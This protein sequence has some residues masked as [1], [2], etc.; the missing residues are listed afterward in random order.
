MTLSALKQATQL[1]GYTVFDYSDFFTK[2]F[3]AGLGLYSKTKT[4]KGL[5]VKDSK[6]NIIIFI[7]DSISEEKQLFVLAHELGH[8]LLNHLDNPNSN[9]K[10]Q[11]I[12]ADRFAMAITGRTSFLENETM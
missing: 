10:Q 2:M 6:G 5:T 7:D 3:L 4:A 9:G 12:E 11:E 1:H 8:I